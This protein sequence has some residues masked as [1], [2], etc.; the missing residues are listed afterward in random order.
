[1]RNFGMTSRET[2]RGNQSPG[3]LH[4]HDKQPD[5]P[6]SPSSF[7]LPPRS[8]L[9]DQRIAQTLFDIA[10]LIGLSLFVCLGGVAVAFAFFVWFFVQ[11]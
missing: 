7:L 6:R 4:G 10:T 1:M 2:V 3:S 9:E 11:T 8:I 5:F